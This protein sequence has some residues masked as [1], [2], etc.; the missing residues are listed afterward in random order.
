MDEADE[1]GFRLVEEVVERYRQ[2]HA[3]ARALLES[4]WKGRMRM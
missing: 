4:E 2:Q 3:D 1:D